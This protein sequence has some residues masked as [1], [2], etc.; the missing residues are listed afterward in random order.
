MK[1]EDAIIQVLNEEGRPMSS[2]EITN[3][4]LERG[5]RKADRPIEDQRQT[6]AGLLSQNKN[7][8]FEH[9]L[10]EGKCKGKYKLKEIV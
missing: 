10:E 4:I 9:E 1:W 6:V 3:K 5:Y 8:R 7:G 2:M